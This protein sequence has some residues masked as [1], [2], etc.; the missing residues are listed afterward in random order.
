MKSAFLNL[1][2]RQHQPDMIRQSTRLLYDQDQTQTRD[3]MSSAQS[4]YILD[5]TGLTRPR[6]VM[7]PDVGIA[8]QQGASLTRDRSLVDVESD[9]RNI[10]R[11]FTLGPDGKY[12]P[13][14]PC[15]NTPSAC[16]RC[17]DPRI[18]S[19]AN[20][21]FRTTS[22]RLANPVK[23]TGR[24]L[25]FNRFQPLF[26]NPQDEQRWLWQT[27]VMM[28]TSLAF[29]DSYVPK[30]PDVTA[31]D[32]SVAQMMPKASAPDMFRPSVSSYTPLFQQQQ[33]RK[34]A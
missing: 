7:V 12:K 2:Q 10:G 17:S 16:A 29:K 8:F 31:M 3:Q 26:W 21:T 4:R 28:N 34:I 9:L 32:Q 33:P 18:S 20:K 25:G 5:N 13:S 23:A 24:E 1:Q 14:C 6:N 15:G 22:T 27:D 30:M 19:L 11:A